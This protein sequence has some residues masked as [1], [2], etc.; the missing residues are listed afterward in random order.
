MKALGALPAMFWNHF[1]TKNRS[2]VASEFQARNR[3]P[4]THTA[5]PFWSHFGLIFWHFRN[6]K[7]IKN[8]IEF[9]RRFRERFLEPPR[10]FG[11]YF[12]LNFAQFSTQ[13][14]IKNRSEFRRQFRE[15]FFEPPETLQSQKVSFCVVKLMF[16]KIG[17]WTPGC[18]QARFWSKN[19]AKMEPKI[20]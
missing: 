5:R 18:R 4:I 9:R 8:R 17:L 14:S 15:R 7:S 3:K 16:L 11:K 12:G 10:T 19:G 20:Y 1:G 6:P 13:K 2:E